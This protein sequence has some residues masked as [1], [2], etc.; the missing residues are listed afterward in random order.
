VSIASL[1]DEYVTWYFDNH[2]IGASTLG[3][4]GYDDRLDDFSAAGFEARRA[5]REQWLRRFEA[6]DGEPDL[7]DGIDRD[8]VVAFLRGERVLDEWPLW[9]R[10]PVHYLT[11]VF[12]SLYQPFLHRLRPDAELVASAVERLRQVPTALSA[13]RANLDPELSSPLLVK[14]G[15]GQAKAG[16]DFVTKALPTEVDDADLRARLLDASGPAAE[17]FDETVEFLTDFAERAAGD[18]RMGEDRY[19][20]LLTEREMLGFGAAEL[21]RRGL[22]AWAELDAQMTELATK[23][24][25]H[26]TDWRSVTERLADDYPPTQEA[27]REEYDAETQ[28]ARKF[29]VENALVSFAEGESCRV[30]PSPNFQRPIFAVAFYFAPPPLTSSRLGHFFVPYTP[31]G[32]TDEQIRERLRSNARAQLPTTSVH[33]AYPGHHWHLSWMASTPRTVRMI[34]RTSYFAEG[35]ALYTEKMMS[36]QGYFTRPEHELAYLEARIFRA[37][38]IVVDTALHTKDMTVQEAEDFM[39]TKGTLNRETAIAEVNR[40]CA[41]PTQAPSYLT[42][43][44][45]I[46]RIRA[47]YL[48]AGRGGLREFHDQLAGSGSLPLGLARRAVMGG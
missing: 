35:W 2:P 46:E 42:G 33:E 40:Y 38:R 45:E 24:D 11:S 47:D 3:A 23:V 25:P 48:A 14:R 10:D 43:S 6:V 31:D 34:F 5:G 41:W 37:A 18:W 9:K 13:L 28:R 15:L 7:D 29:L 4:Q 17:A 30:V 27:M 1:L 8:L 16:R 36:E 12:A 32:F 19:S 21:H 22:D 20:R 39:A 44:L 26:A